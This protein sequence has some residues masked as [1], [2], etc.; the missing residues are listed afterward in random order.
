MAENPNES[1]EDRVWAAD[2]AHTYRP[3]RF[4]HDWSAWSEASRR[5]AAVCDGIYHDESVETEHRIVAARN[6]LDWGYKALGQ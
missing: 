5:L 4:Y 6:L 1:A 2:Y 3:E